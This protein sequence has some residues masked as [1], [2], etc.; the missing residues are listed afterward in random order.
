MRIGIETR[1]LLVPGT[2]IKTY[3][4]QLIKNLKKIKKNS[5][6]LF[7]FWGLNHGV[8]D[9]LIDYDSLGKENFD[10]NVT[11]ER[12]WIEF[13]LQKELKKKKI[14]LYHSLSN[15]HLPVIKV[16]S[17][18]MILTIHDIIPILFPEK[19]GRFGR[20]KYKLA[21]RKADHILTLSENSKKDIMEYLNINSENITVAPLGVDN[22]FYHENIYR[23]KLKEVKNKYGIK[24]KYLLVTGG[25]EYVKNIDMLFKV[26]DIGKKRFFEVFDDIEL[27]ITSPKWAES[28][29]LKTSKNNIN[30]IGYVEEKDFPVIMNG[31]EIFLF[32]SIYEGFG[33]PPLEAMASRTMVISSNSSSLPEVVGDAAITLEPDRPKLWAEKINSV[34]KGNIREKYLKRGVKR[35]EKFSWYK[36]AEKIYEIYEKTHFI[37]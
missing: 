18:P 29:N 11:R 16:V 22:R 34:L 2:G 8:T 21:S 4:K 7:Y 17:T 30:F 37:K 1:E 28:D 15:Y 35:V 3:S 25:S 23:D 20:V 26:M 24:K 31:A 36:F 9:Y 10:K 19:Y 13:D 14:D 6:K 5:D 27:V 33:L 12:V 32:P